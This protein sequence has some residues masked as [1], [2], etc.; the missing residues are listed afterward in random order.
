MLV[1]KNI[2]KLW[3]WNYGII[4]IKIHRLDKN[5]Y[6][7]CSSWL[8]NTNDTRRNNQRISFDF[9]RLLKIIIRDKWINNWGWYNW[10]KQKI[11]KSS[12]EHRCKS[13][14]CFQCY[15]CL[16]SW[17]HR[18]LLLLQKKRKWIR[19]RA[20]MTSYNI[21]CY[22]NFLNYF[23]KFLKSLFGWNLFLL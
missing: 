21:Y 16:N 18:R 5:R 14:N 4:K 19:P 20:K 1:H 13:R 15:W 17:R 9:Q 3:C 2:W 11:R 22:Y 10:G 6:G 23:F 7:A 8:N 12:N